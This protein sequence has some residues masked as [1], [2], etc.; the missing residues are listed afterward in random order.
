MIGIILKKPY[1]IGESGNYETYV[2]PRVSFGA[3]N[4]SQSI[5]RYESIPQY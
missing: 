4:K 1:Q 3:K 2:T 5:A